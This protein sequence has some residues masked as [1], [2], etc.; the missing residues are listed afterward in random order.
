MCGRAAR[1]CRR[2]AVRV[3]GAARP[4]TR[5]SKGKGS[6]A[7][8]QGQG[9]V[10]GARPGPGQAKSVGQPPAGTP[11]PAA[12]HPT[13]SFKLPDKEWR[14]QGAAR[15]ASKAGHAPRYKYDKS[16]RRAACGTGR[17]TH[18][19]SSSHLPSC[20][21]RRFCLYPGRWQLLHWTTRDL[22]EGEGRAGGY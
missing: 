6:R 8:G 20:I 1:W 21:V 14:Q 3:L 22:P 18:A 2:G 10:R 17:R 19:L 16:A 5:N 15:A 9:G 4:P 12:S 11:L 7:K 13:P